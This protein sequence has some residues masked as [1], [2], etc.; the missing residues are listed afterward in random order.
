MEKY[1]KLKDLSDLLDRLYKEPEY[2]HNGETY[3][4]GICAV[5]CEL[6]LLPTVTIPAVQ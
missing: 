6:D 3:Y 2:Q 5:Q 1:V 4:A